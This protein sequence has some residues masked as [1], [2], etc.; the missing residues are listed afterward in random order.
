MDPRTEPPL[1]PVP[2]SPKVTPLLS[3]RAWAWSAVGAVVTLAVFAGMVRVDRTA[4]GTALLE[5]GEW[6]DVPAPVAGR[7]VSVDVGLSQK[8]MAGQVVARLAAASGEAEVFAPLEAMVG[9]VSVK[10]GAEVVEGQP[11]VALMNR[12]VLPSLYVLFPGEFRAELAPGMTF[13]YQLA[14][15]PVPFEAVIEK[16][17]DPETSLQYARAQKDATQSSEQGAVL[18]RAHVPSRNYERDGRSRVYQDGMTGRARVRLGTQRLLVAW[19]PGLRGAV[20]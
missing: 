18:V 15:M 11:V 19:F 4:R 8:V 5:L 16:V 6:V 17:E 1:T 14:G 2:P 9:R 12:N 20:P 7:V 3:R 13:E 10:P